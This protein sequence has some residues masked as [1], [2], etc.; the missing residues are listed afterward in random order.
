MPSPFALIGLAWGFWQKQPA[1]HTVT[2]VLLWLPLLLQAALVRA[3]DPW[4]E[5]QSAATTNAILISFLSLLLVSVVLTWGNACVLIVSKRL[6]G[7]AAGRSR[8]SFKA[9]R[10]QGRGF[11]LPLILTEILRTCMTILW[12]LLLII[13]GIIYTVR[14]AFAS[15]IVVAE[16]IAYRP[17]LKR[18]IETVR[19]RTW[20]VFWRLLALGL[21]LGVPPSALAIIAD[22]TIELPLLADVAVDLVATG[23]TAAAAT[24]FLLSV[25]ALYG[26]LRILA[27]RE[28]KF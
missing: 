20:A 17:A 8:T 21:I 4:M 13:P 25:T 28:V 9:V 12:A 22:Q 15:V 6:L 16:G 1:L 24:M 3:L 23:L 11:I 7:S 10:R 2:A 19:G 18:S 5:T 27:D 26:E 14:T